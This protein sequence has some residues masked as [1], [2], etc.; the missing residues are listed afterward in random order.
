MHRSHNYHRRNYRPPET[1][2]PFTPSADAGLKR[3]FAQIGVPE[4]QP[5]TP[6]PFQL[7]ALDAIPH[8]DC[9]VTAPTGSGK[10]WIAEQAMAR[11]H[12][13]GGRAWYAC[14]LKA[15]SNAK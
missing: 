6:D 7:E 14:P 1:P 15:L 12:R 10:T 3:V 2:A 11:F 8:A 9:L 13:E 5:F 4:S